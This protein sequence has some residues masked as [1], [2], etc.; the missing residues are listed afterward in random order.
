M[1]R[2][3]WQ[4]AYGGPQPPG[5]VAAVCDCGQLG[6]LGWRWRPVTRILLAPL[7]RV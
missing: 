6:C 4:A 2:G 3:E 5:M 7:L 1:T